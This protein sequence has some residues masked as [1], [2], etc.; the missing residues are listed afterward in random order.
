M[1]RTIGLIGGVSWES[2]A[3]YYKEIN[4]IVRRRRGGLASA[5]I[6]LRS[7]DFADI[8]ALQKAGEWR[9]AAAHLARIARQ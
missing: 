7:V 5:D 6:L 4:E 9:Q 3:I 8:V 1:Q 2:T